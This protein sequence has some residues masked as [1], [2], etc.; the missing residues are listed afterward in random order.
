MV[1]RWPAGLLG[2]YVRYYGAPFAVMGSLRAEL[3]KGTTP[4]PWLLPV[5]TASPSL[6]SFTWTGFYVGGQMGYGWGDN[7]GSVSWATA[8]GQAGQSNLTSGA[9]G[10][11]GGAHLGYNQQF[12]HWVLG[13]EGSVDGATLTRNVLVVAPASSTPLLAA[14]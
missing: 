8:Q 5:P 9:Q 1:T 6:P 7:D 14:M 4:P 12:D 11:I 13:L 2:G 10:V 3:D